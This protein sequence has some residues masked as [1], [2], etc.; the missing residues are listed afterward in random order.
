MRSFTRDCRR[1]RFTF[2]TP[3]RLDG[4]RLTLRLLEVCTGDGDVLGAR[5]APS[6]YPRAQMDAFFLTDDQDQMLGG[7]PLALLLSYDI[8]PIANALAARRAGRDGS[9]R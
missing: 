5:R 4:R 8:S 3:E 9:R 6:K 1:D 2:D 7:D